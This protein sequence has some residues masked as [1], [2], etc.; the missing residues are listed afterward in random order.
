MLYSQ[1]EIDI[2]KD[3]QEPGIRNPQRPRIHFERI[4][5]RFFKNYDFK[6]KVILDLGPGQYDFCELVRQKGAIPY[7]I[8]LDESVVRL[9][10]YKKIE[11]LKGNLTDTKVYESFKGKI[12][13]LFCRGSINCSWFK[14]KNEHEEYLNNMLSVLKENGSAWISPCNEPA[15]APFYQN[16]LET[17]L[18]FFE[19][20]NFYTFK[21]HKVQAYMY[22]IWS[23]NPKLI[24]TQNLNYHKLPW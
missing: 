13:L 9:G 21:T 4:I 8:E 17:Q 6:D 24:Y 7:A 14:D 10:Q 3:A 19:R 16:C 20:N 1:A 11:V 12:D 15:T 18:E 23:D 22:G 2:V 5:G